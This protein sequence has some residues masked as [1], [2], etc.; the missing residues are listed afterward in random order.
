MPL[1]LEK[2]CDK[3]HLV[4]FLL[5]EPGVDHVRRH[6]FSIARTSPS[7]SAALARFSSGE[8]KPLAVT[9]SS[10]TWNAREGS[11]RNVSF[12]YSRYAFAFAHSTRRM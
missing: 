1:L 7:C 11:A 10:G 9:M 8:L 3:I 2:D 12:E 4:V 5:N 6:A